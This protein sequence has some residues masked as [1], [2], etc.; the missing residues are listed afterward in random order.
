M[1]VRN[2]Q[3]SLRTGLIGQG[4]QFF[5]AA[6]PERCPALQKKGD[7]TAEPGR[8]IRQIVGRQPFP[9]KH[10]QRQQ[11]CGG[12]GGTAPEP[13]PHRDVF[14]QVKN[15]FALDARSFGNQQGGAFHEVFADRRSPV[16]LDTPRTRGSERD[17][18]LVCEGNG[19]KDGAEFVIA[20]RTL[21]KYAQPEVQLGVRG[22][23]GCSPVHRLKPVPRGLA[24]TACDTTQR[25]TDFSL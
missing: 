17:I 13:R 23:S 21:I 5:A 20:V 8:D 7:I 10:W 6:E 19:L 15:D 9:G 11:N 12:I 1:Y 22:N 18:D 24:A 14:P 2:H 25:G 4:I 3:Q 16:N